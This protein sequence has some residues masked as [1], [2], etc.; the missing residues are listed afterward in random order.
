MS[1]YAVVHRNARDF[2]LSMVARS[3][4]GIKPLTVA[5]FNLMP[6]CTD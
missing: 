6:C 2:I 3:Q 5:V 1:R 4:V